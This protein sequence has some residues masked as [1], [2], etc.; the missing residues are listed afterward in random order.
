[1]ATNLTGA[2]IHTVKTLHSLPLP[3]DKQ[4]YI[5]L[6]SLGENFKKLIND[7]HLSYFSLFSIIS[8]NDYAMNS[9]RNLC[10]LPKVKS[11]GGGNAII[12][13]FS[14][15]LHLYQM[16]ISTKNL[17]SATVLESIRDFSSEMFQEIKMN[18]VV[19]VYGILT[20][21]NINKS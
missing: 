10:M 13:M 8:W 2:K 11:H 18:S 7:L 6:Y 14:P 1:M 17:F 21:L 12:S 4:Y 16:I 15:S 20:W 5:F 3:S 9:Q 19:V